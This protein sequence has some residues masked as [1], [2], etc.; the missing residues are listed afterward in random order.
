VLVTCAA[1]ARAVKQLLAHRL[2]GSNSNKAKADWYATVMFV[3]AVL[4]LNTC[5]HT[6]LLLCL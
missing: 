5:N 1:Q 6:F 4:T 2:P 3:A